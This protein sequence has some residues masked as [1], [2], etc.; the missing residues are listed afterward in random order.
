MRIALADYKYEVVGTGTR[1]ILR[2]TYLT[3]NSS[4]SVT[5]LIDFYE[6]NVGKRKIELD[7]SELDSLDVDDKILSSLQRSIK[8]Y[9]SFEQ[10]SVNELIKS[11]K[12]E[13][14][15]KKSFKDM[16]QFLEQNPSSIDVKRLEPISFRKEVFK[17]VNQQYCGFVNPNQRE[18]VVKQFTDQFMFEKYKFDLL[19]FSDLE[20]NLFLTKK[21]RPTA[22]ELISNYNMD[23]IETALYHSSSITI[24]LNKLSGEIAKNIVFISKVNCVFSSIEKTAD[25]YFI[26]IEPPFE[27]Y[28]NSKRW[29]KNLCSVAKYI[30][31]A[32]L[33]NRLTL[34]IKAVVQLRKRKLLYK[35]NIS[36]QTSFPLPSLETIFPEEELALDSKV[37][38]EFY[39]T[40][41]NYYGWQT[42][43]EPEVIMLGNRLMIPDFVLRRGN[44]EVYLEIV[45]YYTSEYIL[46]KKK[47][48][49][50]LA[51]LELP[52]IY[53]INEELKEHFKDIRNIDIV[54]YSKNF[55]PNR[56]ILKTLDEK[57]SDYEE[58]EPKLRNRFKS[59][60]YENLQ[61]NRVLSF[62]D[63]MRILDT[64]SLAEVK[65]FLNSPQTTPLIKEKNLVFIPSFGCVLYDLINEIQAEI[66]ENNITSVNT[67]K[68]KYSE[69]SEII[70]PILQFLD[71]KT[72]WH[73]I[74]EII[75]IK[76]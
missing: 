6:T 9:Y 60:S 36:K 59:I 3:F 28:K 58:R 20:A 17:F 66:E 40:W 8:R 56:K 4:E 14:K 31:R 1:S 21:K 38:E 29:S 16:A 30:I 33:K 2:P 62:A 51:K 73:S 68:Q 74:N 37:E 32:A 50:A 41:K 23:A 39:K 26:S 57:Y 76:E 49:E 18:T 64:Y 22:I 55:I 12:S 35:L 34:E 70:L 42:T 43:A 25:N 47:K 72:K 54:Y 46:K 53:L 27:A 10:K 5:V 65:K 7:F 45:G 61:K 52:I 48:M 15:T 75:I 13:N 19:L 63:F 71:Y 69:I 24:S 44:I 67:L 11:D